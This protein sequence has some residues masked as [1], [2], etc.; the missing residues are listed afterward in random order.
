[1]GIWWYRRSSGT[2][3]C[4]GSSRV[5]LPI[6]P[7]HV[8]TV[9][10]ALQMPPGQVTNASGSHPFTLAWPSPVVVYAKTGNTAVDGER[11]SWLVGAVE[12]RGTQHVVVARVRTAGTLDGTAGLEAARRALDRFA[13]GRP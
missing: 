1:M 7:A 11:V 10:R 5:R 6:D 3:S 12:S 13:A 8:A 9:R 4:S 2:R